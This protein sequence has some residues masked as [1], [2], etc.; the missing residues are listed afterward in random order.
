MLVCFY[1][2]SN[3]W[4]PMHPQID[5]LK[6]NLSKA[7]TEVTELDRLIDQIREVCILLSS[8]AGLQQA[9]PQYFIPLS[10]GSAC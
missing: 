8:G 1:S 10:T 6:K 9:L 7:D 2:H 3:A 5:V 4:Y